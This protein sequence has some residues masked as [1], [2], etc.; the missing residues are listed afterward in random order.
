MGGL[1]Y[2][3]GK[4]PWGLL[5]VL[6]TEG[7]LRAFWYGQ[8]KYTLCADCRTNVYRNP[9][10]DGD[11]ERDDCP[12]CGSRNLID[13]AWNWHRGFRLMRIV[14]SL[15][16]HLFDIIKGSEEDLESGLHPAD[17]LMANAAMLAEHLYLNLGIDDRK[18]LYHDNQNHSTP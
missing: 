5:P 8:R 6:A 9:R 16:R 13:G 17:H 15:L 11:P 4:L 3:G 12:G 18:D 2:D 14:A 7:M 10:L 1:K